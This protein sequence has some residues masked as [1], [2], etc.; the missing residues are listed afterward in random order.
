MCYVCGDLGQPPTARSHPRQQQ[1][2]RTAFTKQ[3]PTS[4]GLQDSN[5]AT[6]REQGC[7]K[8][9]FGKG[10]LQHQHTSPSAPNI[11]IR[12]EENLST[13]FFFLLEL[14]FSSHFR[15]QY[16]YWRHFWIWIL[17]KNVGLY[18]TLV[19]Q[20]IGAGSAIQTQAYLYSRAKL[21]KKNMELQ[22]LS[23]FSQQ[24]NLFWVLQQYKC[25]SLSP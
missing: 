13:S 23:V 4:S 16:K 8:G 12:A 1:H 11:H 7:I 15:S 10:P 18:L 25:Q 19:L 9:H 5:P 20:V 21:Q 24:H 17:L 6:K 14:N 22:H 3:R 2:G